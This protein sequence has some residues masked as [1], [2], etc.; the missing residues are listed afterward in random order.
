MKHISIGGLDVSRIGLGTM[1]MSG[2]YPRPGQ[3]RR[4]VDPHHPASTGVGR[5]PTSTRPRSTAP[6]PT[7]NSFGRAMKGRRDDAVVA[8]KF[9][10]VLAPPAEALEC[11]TAAGRN[12][13]T[14]LEGSLKAARDR[15]IDLYNQPPGRPEHAHRGQP[16]A[17][18]AELVV[19]VPRP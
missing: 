11:W 16:S 15:R 5:H 13:R 10:L 3:Q 8:T 18:L 4:R 1:A 7:R 12:I 17:S 14:A 9:G 19:G 2:Y 6:T